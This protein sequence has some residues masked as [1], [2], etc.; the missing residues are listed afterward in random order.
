MAVYPLS[1]SS[2]ENYSN[3]NLGIKY[4]GNVTDVNTVTNTPGVA[5]SLN[6]LTN[7]RDNRES[8]E[9]NLRIGS[10][11]PGHFTIAGAPIPVINIRIADSRLELITS[12]N[13]L[14]NGLEAATQ[15][16]MVCNIVGL[17]AGSGEYDIA[18]SKQDGL[19]YGAGATITIP[20]T[21]L[22]LLG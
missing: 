2:Q 19:A 4:I 18:L 14:I 6:V 22:T 15:T 16:S 11:G 20:T 17:G 21:I 8:P 5:G 3:K 7:M 13:N 12:Q 9:G 1:I 10:I